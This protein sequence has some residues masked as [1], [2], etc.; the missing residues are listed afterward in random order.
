[1]NDSSVSRLGTE[2]TVSQLVNGCR[3]A[4]PLLARLVESRV[5]KNGNTYLDMMLADRTG[6]INAKCWNEAAQ[7]PKSGSV[8]IITATV[9][10]F[11]NKLQLKTDSIRQAADGDRIDMT[12]LVA[13]APRSAEEM[14]K[15]ILTAAES[16]KNRK[17]TELVKEML[18]DAGDKLAYFPAAQRIHHAEKGGL[19]HHTTDMMSMAEKLIEIYPWLDRDLLLAGVIIHDLGKI[20]EFICDDAGNVSDY[21]SD[22]LLVGHV[23]RDVTLLDRAAA[24]T[25]MEGELLL[26]LEHMMISHHGKAEY[27]SPKPPMF[28]EAEALHMLDLLDSQMF[29]FRNAVLNTPPGGFA[30][31]VPGIEQRIYHPRYGEE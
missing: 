30:D 5:D 23:V 11:K 25:G 17:L 2:I 29:V 9:T 24:K 12:Q 3:V 28:P 10:E 26:L 15:Q 20:S 6:E 22:G 8:V 27:G 14:K 16:F 4:G 31:R 21:S 18:K 1:M 13:S 7:P 19:L